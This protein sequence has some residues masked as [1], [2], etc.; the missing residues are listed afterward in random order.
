MI[1]RSA[2]VKNVISFAR[3]GIN[4]YRNSFL[5]DLLPLL[6]KTALIFRGTEIHIVHGWSAAMLENNAF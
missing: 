6:G 3:S 1:Q 5:M 4:D 2:S